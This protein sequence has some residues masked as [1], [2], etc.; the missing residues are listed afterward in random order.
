MAKFTFALPNGKFFE[1]I[2]PADATVA[3]AEKIFLQQLAAGAIVG[4]ADGTTLEAPAARLIKFT[5][6]RLDRGTAGTADLPLLAINNQGILSAL[7]PLSDTQVENGI[8]VADFWT[9]NPRP[10]WDHSHPRRYRPWP[11][12]WPKTWISRQMWSL[13]PK[14]W[15]NMV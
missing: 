14:A 15:A 4:L 13:V 2:G 10:Q 3:Q 7:P 5:Q 12:K 9:P 6:S 11:R 8:N 1:L